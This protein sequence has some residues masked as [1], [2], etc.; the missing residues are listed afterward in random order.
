M[1]LDNYVTRNEF[2]SFVTWVKCW[3]QFSYWSTD[4]YV[5]NIR[6]HFIILLYHKQL[7]LRSE[8]EKLETQLMVAKEKI[9]RLEKEL[10]LM[11]DIQTGF[12]I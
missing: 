8:H 6:H 11:R 7:Y 9:K 12:L 2:F 10:K 5:A 4:I 1:D 3:R